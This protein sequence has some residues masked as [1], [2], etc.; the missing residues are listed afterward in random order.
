LVRA[1]AISWTRARD[2]SAADHAVAVCRRTRAAPSASSVFGPVNLAECAAASC[3]SRARKAPAADK[4]V[5][6]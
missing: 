5:Y 6:A 2:A 3:S 4:A 1:A